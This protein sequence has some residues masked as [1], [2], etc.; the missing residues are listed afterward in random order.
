MIPDTSL[1]TTLKSVS[2]SFYLS[3]RILPIGMRESVAIAY[4]LARAADTIADTAIIKREIRLKLL[5]QYRSLLL[6]GFNGENIQELQNLLLPQIKDADEK[7]LFSAIQQIFESFYA[8][9]SEDFS[10]VQKVVSTLTDGM[11]LDLTTFTNEKQITAIYSDADLDRYTYL[12][13]G[14]VGEFWTALSLRHVH[15]IKHWDKNH[16]LLLGIEFGKA[17]QLTNIVRDIAKDVKLNRCYIPQE[18]LT[19]NGLNTQHLL[20]KN[21]DNLLR[22]IVQSMIEHALEYFDSAEKYLTAIPRR[23]IRLRLA[24]LW[25]ILIGLKTLMLVSKK[26]NFLDP[27]VNIKV[28][29]MWVYQMLFLS[30]IAIFSNSIIQRWIQK[31]TAQVR[32]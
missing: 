10:S 28:S 22:P 3:M 9:T 24:A 13:A 31:L 17:L 30:A 18:T 19:A 21:N 20:N 15:T 5:Y 32:Q 29:R 27:A 25:P 26:G 14:C 12:V 2:R 16:Y 1:Y 6:T 23:A 11:L 8:L 4:L 7:K